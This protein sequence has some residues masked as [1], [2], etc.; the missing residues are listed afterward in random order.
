MG[1]AKVAKS[2]KLNEPFLGS[3]TSNEGKIPWDYICPRGL[4]THR[5]SSNSEG[6]MCES[7]VNWYGIT[8]IL[9]YTGQ[10]SSQQVDQ[11]VENDLANFFWSYSAVNPFVMHV[12]H[13]CGLHIIFN[14]V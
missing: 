7:S 10:Y 8:H 5:I 9:Y 13:D 14:T 2:R 6:V 12:G 11:E 4:P 1:T 3:H